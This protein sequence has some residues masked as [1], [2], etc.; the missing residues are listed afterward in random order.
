MFNDIGDA[1]I[2]IT[3]E[4]LL[5]IATLGLLHHI[6][7]AYPSSQ[8]LNKYPANLEKTVNKAKSLITKTIYKEITE[9]GNTVVCFRDIPS[10]VVK[11]SSKWDFKTNYSMLYNENYT[12]RNCEGG[13]YRDSNSLVA[14][15]QNAKVLRKIIK[16]NNLK[17]I[18]VPK[19][20]LCTY[21][22]H[23]VPDYTFLFNKRCFV[24]AQYC[25]A[26]HPT[27]EKFM[28]DIAVLSK[29]EQKQ[30]ARELVIF[31]K[32]SGII[33]FHFGNFIIKDKKFVLFD[34]E[35]FS[36][37]IPSYLSCVSAPFREARVNYENVRRRFNGIAEA[38]VIVSKCTKAM[39][40][41]RLEED[42]LFRDL[43]QRIM[44]VAACI[45]LHILSPLP[46]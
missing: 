7:R 43:I 10:F 30:L 20:Y 9:N 41:I 12:A 1:V 19:K 45:L 37:T 25:D 3:L 16:A 27:R 31:L 23:L 36:L 42:I 24:L 40:K 13:V 33:D 17:M 4:P 46:V 32:Y 26:K 14:R 34:T 6:Y 8:I 22:S 11:G 39:Q 44:A 15:V 29:D 28:E 18:F 2:S 35:P 5:A 38:A 21:P